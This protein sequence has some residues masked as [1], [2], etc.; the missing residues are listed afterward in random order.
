MSSAL[1]PPRIQTQDPGAHEL[2]G[3]EDEH[4][5]SASEGDNNDH[6]IPHHHPHQNPNRLSTPGTPITRVERVDSTPAYGEVPGTH[7]YSIRTADAVPDEVEIVP[8]GARSRSGTRSR[9]MSNL[10]EM[11]GRG[12]PRPSTPGGTVIP[13]TVVERVDDKP[14]FG[15]VE[16]TLA[17]E[18]RAAD[19]EPDEVL[20]G[21][22]VARDGTIDQGRYDERVV[23]EDDNP[24]Q[25]QAWL[26]STWD[27][28]QQEVDVQ[29]EED[30]VEQD[31]GDNDGFGDDF[32]DFNEGD[33][34]EDFGDFD[35]AEAE[36]EPA[37]A[38]VEEAPPAPGILAGLPPLNISSLSS[39]DTKSAMQPYISAIFPS[40]PP[41]PP[42][43]DLPPI[44]PSKTSPFLSDRSL[45]L[46]QQ[47]VSPPPMQPPNWTRSRIRRLFLVSLGVP[48]D[49]D[50]I[51][52]PSKQK[53]LV[54]PNINLLSSPRPSTA[55]E[56]L[57]EG[58]GND[59]TTS[60]DSRTGAAKAKQHSSSSR[61][62]GKGVP[63]P[64]EFDLN[65][66]ALLC[67][68]TEQAMAGMEDEELREFVGRLGR[69]VGEASGVLEYWVQRKDE[70]V[71]EKEAL[72]GVVGNLVGWVK[73]RRGK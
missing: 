13:K 54:L 7:A 30:I 24:E 39:R 56:R 25:Q 58:E 38:I 28:K 50:E 49:L 59:S 20:R 5:S 45:A 37:A 48:V 23:V 10:S 19:A 53:R 3:S 18:L 46:W 22:E 2:S 47:L 71:R 66:A 9:A 33:G 21:P 15:E 17:K 70:G 29:P 61:R 41:L 42:L 6:N 72:E 32:D 62:A 63:G 14:A 52:P 27:S 31:D 34:E 60:L 44:D 35:E 51:L 65:G 40:T 11:S 55:V 64:P 8:E 26:R 68:V 1:K 4:F 57:R 12:S 36:A 73:G 16:G 69:V 67:R 43:H